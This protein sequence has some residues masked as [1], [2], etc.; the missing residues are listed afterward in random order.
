MS[1]PRFERFPARLRELIS[2]DYQVDWP[3]PRRDRDREPSHP[4]A[5]METRR[6]DRAIAHDWERDHR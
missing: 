6:R 4:W 2:N 1:N 5:R 3:R